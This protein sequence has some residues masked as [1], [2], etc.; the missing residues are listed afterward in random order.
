MAAAIGER[1]GPAAKSGRYS[2]QRPTEQ[3]CITKPLAVRLSDSP[4]TM[5]SN[6]N[7]DLIRSHEILLASLY[8]YSKITEYFIGFYI[9]LPS[10]RI[11]V[12]EEVDIG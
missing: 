1:G 7:C 3:R 9:Q 12:L 5:S 10:Y 6:L 2:G 4:L 11:D 8:I